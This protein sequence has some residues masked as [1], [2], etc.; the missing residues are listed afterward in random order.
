MGA[1]LLKGRR[2]TDAD[3]LDAPSVVLISEALERS[4]FRGIDPIGRYMRMKV[5]RY[6]FNSQIVGV[7]KDMSHLRLGEPPR[8][9][10]YQPYS[11]LPWPFLAFA[12]RTRGD[13]NALM[14]S[15]RNV[16]WA[17]DADVPVDRI[18]PLE[19]L[20]G[21]SLAQQ[22]LAMVLLSV[23]AAIAVLLSAVGLY[24]VL[25][26][27]VAQRK[28]EFGIRMALGATVGDVLALVLRH[29]VLLSLAGL[30]LGL[31]CMPL[32]TQ[33]MSKMLYGVKP[34][35]PLTFV[36][37]GVVILVVA[38]AA[39]LLPGIRASRTDPASALHAE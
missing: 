2:F 11:Q 7:V 5:S 28:R 17:L 4:L 38:T 13:M 3:T 9:A 14:P 34:V 18:L 33:L 19:K 12:V 26:V 25:G 10:I 6:E 27:A 1:T 39:S 21:Q 31:A 30:A 20:V 8:V 23:F 37:V 16:F 22:K 35:D 36:T 24:G 15:V 29:G 32:A